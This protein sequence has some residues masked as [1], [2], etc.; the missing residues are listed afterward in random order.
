MNGMAVPNLIYANLV[1]LVNPVQIFP[2]NCHQQVTAESLLRIKPG[3][4]VGEP[5]VGSKLSNIVEIILVRIFGMNL[6]PGSKINC[7]VE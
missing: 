1:H 3:M 7:H 6:F 5:G 2:S 4:C